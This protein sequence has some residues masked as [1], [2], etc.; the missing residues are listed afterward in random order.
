MVVVEPVVG[1]SGVLTG[2][3]YVIG[4]ITRQLGR[5]RDLGRILGKRAI[6]SSDTSPGRT[7]SSASLTCHSF[8]S[9]I[10]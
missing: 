5:S 10:Q 3:L 8:R 1:F 7:S 9:G 6:A 2:W 4:K